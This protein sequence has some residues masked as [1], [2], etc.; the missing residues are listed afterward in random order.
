[1]AYLGENERYYL[2]ISEPEQKGC[3]LLD[4][5]SFIN[6]FG[7]YENKDAAKL[8]L[9][10]HGRSICKEDAVTKLSEL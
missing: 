1:M 7:T 9:S 5:Y 6:E 10:E 4:K 2:F 8:Y 3:I